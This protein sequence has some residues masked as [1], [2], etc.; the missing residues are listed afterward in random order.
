MYQ[1][2]STGYIHFYKAGKLIT[3]KK[4]SVSMPFN[5][6]TSFLQ[7][8]NCFCVFEFY[9]CQCPSTGYI[10]FYTLPFWK[11]LFIRLWRMRFPQD[12]L[13][14]YKSV[15]FFHFLFLQNSTFYLVNIL[16]LFYFSISKIQAYITKYYLYLVLKYHQK[17]YIVSDYFTYFLL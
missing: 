4:I 2:P 5:G 9:M 7:N 12:F 1:C 14:C 16:I 11:P 6:L 3:A 8:G 10:H 13:N 15:T 17:L